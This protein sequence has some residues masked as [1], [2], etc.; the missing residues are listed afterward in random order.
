MSNNFNSFLLPEALCCTVEA[1]CPPITKGFKV[2]VYDTYFF[3]IS[4]SQNTRTW[5]LES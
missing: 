4:F 1:L 3:R 2:K 5:R